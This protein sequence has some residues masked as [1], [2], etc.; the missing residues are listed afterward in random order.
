MVPWFCHTNYV[1]FYYS[2]CHVHTKCQ[3]NWLSPTNELWTDKFL[4]TWTALINYKLRERQRAHINDAL[5][6]SGRWMNDMTNL[7][8]CCSVPEMQM[9][10]QRQHGQLLRTFTTDR[11]TT[12]QMLCQQTGQTTQ[13]TQWISRSVEDD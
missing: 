2:H 12:G 3:W 6:G 11:W 8:E 13:P 1:I 5:S 4:D 7:S 9:C 10:I